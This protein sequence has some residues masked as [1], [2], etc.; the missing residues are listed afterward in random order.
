MEG[1]Y[2]VRHVPSAIFR[3]DDRPFISTSDR[4]GMPATVHRVPSASGPPPGV[5]D[6]G[7]TG[8]TRRTGPGTARPAENDSAASARGGPGPRAQRTVNPPSTVRTCPTT[9]LD[10]GEAR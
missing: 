1:S 8:A 2:A 5:Y 9:K 4:F 3:K 10:S 7:P 6:L